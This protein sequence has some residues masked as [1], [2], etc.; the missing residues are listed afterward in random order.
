MAELEIERLGGTA[1]A[2]AAFARMAVAVGDARLAN[3]AIGVGRTAARP[4]VTAAR[5]L[6]EPD[7]STRGHDKQRA[8]GPDSHNS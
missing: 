6:L 4:T 1:V 5:A 2:F 7:P 8:C 3:V